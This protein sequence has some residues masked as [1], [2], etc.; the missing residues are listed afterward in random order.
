MV[1]QQKGLSYGF[2]RK[3]ALSNLFL[4]KLGGERGQPSKNLTD[5]VAAVCS[6]NKYNI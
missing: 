3:N 2:G 6:L 5:T 4:I 1:M